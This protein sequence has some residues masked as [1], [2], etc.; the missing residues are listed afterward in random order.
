MSGLDWSNGSSG[1]SAR[2]GAYRLGKREWLLI[3]LVV[4]V[5]IPLLALSGIGLPLP[6]S[7]ERGLASLLPGGSGVGGTPAHRSDVGATDVKASD[8]SIDPGGRV[9]N[10]G[11]GSTGSAGT[12]T[13][14]P[15]VDSGGHAGGDAAPG[16]G[17][18]A[19]GGSGSGSGSG[20]GSG[21]WSSP[22]GGGST[23]SGSSVVPG[24][25]SSPS[26]SVTTTGGTTGVSVDGGSAGAD[27]G[28]SVGDSGSGAS[29]G[30]SAPDGTT[31]AVS[32]DGSGSDAGLTAPSGTSA[33]A[34]TDGS[35]SDA[36]ATVG[37]TVPSDGSAPSVSVGGLP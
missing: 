12:R 13:T 31:A 36:G 34:S 29:T 21:S 1:V 17:S 11:N 19:G 2:S 10:H 25:G 3:G 4:L 33:G 26:V 28:V 14:T 35:S 32:V 24:G 6:G 5:P 30:V 16:G 23:G 8:H 22:A 15:P 27:A 20:P 7:V 37:V 18:T 9:A